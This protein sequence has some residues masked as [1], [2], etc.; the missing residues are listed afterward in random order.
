MDRL[1]IFKLVDKLIGTPLCFLLGVIDKPFKR[2]LPSPANIKKILVIKLVAIGDLVVALPTLRALKQD[3]PHAHLAL[4]TT[5][6]VREVVEGCP[7]L[8]EIIYYDILGKDKGI[9]GLIKLI[10]ILKGKRFDLALELDHY[11]RITSLITYLSGIKNR[12][13]FDLPGQGRRGLITVKSP[14]LTN[15]HEVEAFLEMANTVGA[16]NIQNTPTKLVPIW[17]SKKDE[18]DISLFFKQNKI[19]FDD[20]VVAMH[21]GTGPSAICR[22]WAVRRFATLADWLIK[23]YNAKVIFTGAPSEVELVNNIL[24]FMQEKP[25]VAAGR[26]SLKQLA[27][28][29][30]RCKL[31][32]SVDTGP[33]HVAAAMGTR[34]IGLYGPNIP[35][36]WGPYGEGHLTIYKQLPCSPCTKQYLGQVSRCQNPICMEQITV[37]DVKAQVNRINAE[38]R[39]AKAREC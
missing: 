23:E 29:A 26:T 14:Y 39:N 18:K 5:P 32:I 8:D 10:R 9:I 17:T 25:I 30:R 13:G 38:S 27:E 3:F 28:I 19:K 15:K 16:K 2:K 20:F 1:Q 35:S 33:L 4:M 21:P 12:V 6:R 34:V 24:A 7:Y 31:F 22:R 37:E 36:K 11:Y